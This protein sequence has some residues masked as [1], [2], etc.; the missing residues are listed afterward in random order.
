MYVTPF[1]TIINGTAQM[2]TIYHDRMKNTVDQ[3]ICHALTG[4]CFLTVSTLPRVLLQVHVPA[5]K[6]LILSTI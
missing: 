4:G 3:R 2:N 5:A 6:V 1:F